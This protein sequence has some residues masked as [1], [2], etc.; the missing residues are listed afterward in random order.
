MSTYNKD[1]II[2]IFAESANALVAPNLA[3][4][5]STVQSSQL[6]HCQPSCAVDGEYSDNGREY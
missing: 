2:I 5:K 1:I 6:A 3:L 4:G